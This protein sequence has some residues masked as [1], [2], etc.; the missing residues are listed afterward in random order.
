[1]SFPA[2]IA[3][4]EAWRPPPGRYISSRQQLELAWGDLGRVQNAN[5]GKEQPLISPT[6]PQI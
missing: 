3:L 4:D 5:E 6:C 1:M 2:F